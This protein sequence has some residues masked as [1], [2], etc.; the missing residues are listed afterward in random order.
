MNARLQEFRT[1][2]QDLEKLFEKQATPEGK[3]FARDLRN[4]L[5]EIET[6][7]ERARH[8]IK[9]P[10][11]AARLAER[12]RKLTEKADSRNFA[13]EAKLAED[14]RIIAGAQDSL[15]GR[16]RA[17]IRRAMYKA[18]M[19]NPGNPDMIQLIREIRKRGRSILYGRPFPG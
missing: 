14:I 2:R 12:I 5:D 13:V 10:Q 7:W 17:I 19:A 4:I 1:L 6:E 15:V 11:Y 3:A 18:A 16:Y 8:R 9:N